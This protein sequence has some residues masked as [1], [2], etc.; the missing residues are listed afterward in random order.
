MSN[1]KAQTR[2]SLN[3]ELVILLAP[4]RQLVRI[5]WSRSSSR[6]TCQSVRT[7]N[8]DGF[9]TFTGSNSDISAFRS[10][11]RISHVYASVSAWA[12]HSGV[13][14]AF[15]HRPSLGLSFSGD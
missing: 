9:G 10:G 4:R 3:V 2:C 1:W 13:G 8:D 12:G 14:V 5:R 6:H 7:A 15:D 11:L